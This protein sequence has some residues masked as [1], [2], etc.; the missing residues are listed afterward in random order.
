[1]AA[2]IEHVT[3]GLKAGAF[4]GL[5]FGLFVA[6][7]GNPL[8]AY[9]ETFEHGHGG[10]PVVPETAT[11]AVSVGGGVLLGVLLGAV[12]FGAAFYFVEPAIPGPVEARSYLLAAAGFV[13]VSGSPWVLL[14]PQ[15]PGVEQALATDVRLTWYAIMMAVGAAACLLSGYAY[16]RLRARHGP[17]LGLLG[18]LVAFGLIPAAAVVGPAN[19]VTGSIPADLAY[20][21]RAVTAVGQVG[22]WLVI[23]GAHALMLRR[24]RG[25]G[26]AEPG[27]EPLDRHDTA[28][29]D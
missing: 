13:T 9:A 7:V 14:P 2:L 27:P 21:F 6:L 3:R 4:G 23:A 16:S 17:A 28:P 8:V 19:A 29:A 12:V 24:D 1:M 18:A 26:S 5:A 15:P 25:A 11:I 20:V 10:G 22:L